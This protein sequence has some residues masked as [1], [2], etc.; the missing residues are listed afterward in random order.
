[1]ILL[2]KMFTLR[3]LRFEFRFVKIAI[4]RQ[5]TSLFFRIFLQE[6]EL[7]NEE[8]RQDCHEPADLLCLTGTD[9]QDDI[10]NQSEEDA[11]GD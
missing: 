11:I 7:Q 1:M 8:H 9:V 4:S 2:T 6:N 5:K 3:E 10:G